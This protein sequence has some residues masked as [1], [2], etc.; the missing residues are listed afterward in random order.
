MSDD[1]KGNYIFQSNFYTMSSQGKG[2]K[3]SF[4]QDNAL[5]ASKAKIN[6]GFFEWRLEGFQRGLGVK[7]KFQKTLIL[8]FEVFVQPPK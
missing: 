1:V 5:L 2:R 4:G 7:K 8:V 3:S 6:G